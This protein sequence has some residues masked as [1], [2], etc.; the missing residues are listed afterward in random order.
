L[1]AMVARISAATA[2]PANL[3]CADGWA[4]VE[5]GV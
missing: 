3:A 5:N 1:A 4:V 2:L